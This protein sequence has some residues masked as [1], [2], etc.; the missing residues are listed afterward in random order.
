MQHI[1]DRYMELESEVDEFSSLQDENDPEYRNES[2][3]NFLVRCVGKLHVG[4]SVAAERMFLSFAIQNDLGTQG[5]QHKVSGAFSKGKTDLVR[6]VLSLVGRECAQECT[7]SD[8]SIFYS[9]DFKE[10]HILFSDDKKLSPE[11]EG[12]IKRAS[13]NFQ[14][15]TVFQTL[16]KMNFA[17]TKVM[18]ARIVWLLTGVENTESGE[19]LSRCVQ[20]NIDESKKS[21]RVVSD[22]IRKKSDLNNHEFDLSISDVQRCHDIFK[23]IRS[24]YFFVNIP[25]EVSMMCPIKGRREL[26]MFL[27][28]VRGYAIFDHNNRK[29]IIRSKVIAYKKI[30]EIQNLTNDRTHKEY[31]V[32]YKEVPVVYIDAN[33]NDVRLALRVYHEDID[34]EG[35][36]KYTKSEQKIIDVIPYTTEMAVTS[37]MIQAA[38]G[39]SNATVSKLLH[40]DKSRNTKGLC[41]RTD[42][43][44]FEQRNISIRSEEETVSRSS[45]HYW[46]IDAP[47]LK[48]KTP[49][50]NKNR[51]NSRLI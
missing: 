20:T 12:I 19:L 18:P 27:D 26:K 22:F 47:P 43:I 21:D 4:D 28:H 45:F 7:M 38:T 31:S 32:G 17:V 16:N 46:R 51:E 25:I 1:I 40:G 10:G 36:I 30:D 42:F 39:L 48:M 23:N 9:D 11:L 8:K 3:I 6:S 14:E 29:Q 15:P 44:Q 50:E 33:E 49:H 37:N 34:I 41:E 35:S 2:D 24:K 13:S 5:I